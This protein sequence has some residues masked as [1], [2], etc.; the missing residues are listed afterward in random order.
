M[1]K[2]LTQYDAEMLTALYKSLDYLQCN[3]L[4]GQQE[5]ITAIENIEAKTK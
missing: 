4:P 1:I 2:Q 3:D 5:L